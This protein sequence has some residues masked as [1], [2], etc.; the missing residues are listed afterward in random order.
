MHEELHDCLKDYDTTGW[1]WYCPDNWVPH[2]TLALTKEDE[3]SVFYRA[4]DLILHEFKK[5]SGEFVAI[6]LVKMTF[7][8]SSAN[9][10]CSIELCCTI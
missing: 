6:G 1:E 7:P 4:S 2:C 10:L 3:N 8:A 5:M 9:E